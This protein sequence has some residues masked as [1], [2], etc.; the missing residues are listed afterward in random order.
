M[1]F[2]NA[3]ALDVLLGLAVLFG[4][5]DG[6]L[7]AC[8]VVEVVVCVTLR[9]DELLLMAATLLPSGELPPHPAIIAA[10]IAALN[11]TPMRGARRC[12]SPRVDPGGLLARR[13]LTICMRSASLTG[14]RFA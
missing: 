11:N 4:V 6:L 3:S 9:T 12:R 8:V 13:R 5:V 2:A 7:L 14:S 10:T 1:H